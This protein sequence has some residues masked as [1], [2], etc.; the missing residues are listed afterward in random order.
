MSRRWS[1]WK[2]KNTH[3]PCKRWINIHCCKLLPRSPVRRALRL[4]RISGTDQ[5]LHQL[6]PI[7]R[8][9]MP[10]R[11][12]HFWNC[13]Y[14]HSRSRRPALH[15]SRRFSLWRYQAQLFINITRSLAISEWLKVSVQS[16]IFIIILINIPFH[17]SF[18][19]IALRNVQTRSSYVAVFKIMPLS[20]PLGHEYV[21]NIP[22]SYSTHGDCFCAS[23]LF[24][25][26]MRHNITNRRLELT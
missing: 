19:L 17:Y 8:R 4:R 21:L 13:L 22:Q 12:L 5:S 18:I 16:L 9:T 14:T 3:F 1:G 15:L 7:V 6:L 10:N 11:H 26:L 24:C 2:P 25:A 23:F 20:I